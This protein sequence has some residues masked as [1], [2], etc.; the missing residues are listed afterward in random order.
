[1]VFQM[2]QITRLIGDR[3]AEYR[4]LGNDFGMTCFKSVNGALWLDSFLLH[5]GSPILKLL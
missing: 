2:S 3:G 1:M 5:Y 4:T